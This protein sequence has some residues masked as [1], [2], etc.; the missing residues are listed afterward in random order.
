MKRIIALILTAVM[1]LSLAACGSGKKDSGSNSGKKGDNI[2]IVDRPSLDEDPDE[3]YDDPYDDPDEP[4]DD[5]DEP[6]DD[7]DEP[8]DDPD[9]PYDDPDEPYD[10]PEPS[11]ESV[12]YFNYYGI[13][14]NSDI[15]SRVIIKN[16]GAYIDTDSE[17]YCNASPNFT[18]ECTEYS[19]DDG[20]GYGH[21]KFQITCSFNRD[22]PSDFGR[23]SVAYCGE[24][25]DTF[26]GDVI[27]P[28]GYGDDNP[29]RRWTKEYSA[30]RPDGY[31]D[32][33]VTCESVTDTSDKNLL[34]V[35]RDTYTIVFTTGYSGVDYV[36]IPAPKNRDAWEEYSNQGG[37]TM[38][39]L[40]DPYMDIE[41]SYIFE[42]M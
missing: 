33:K 3:P 31:Y 27:S 2:T 16:C 1:V 28:T 12:G 34:I 25:Y 32:V 6:Y 4:Y 10:E 41:N 7:P 21:A 5:P 37:H 20:Y 40:D 11:P 8:Y 23:T 35:F 17:K 13:K 14:A 18:I 24:F 22:L 39:I 42:L 36:A 9:E 38:K 26:S 30:I 29:D 19:P 15:G